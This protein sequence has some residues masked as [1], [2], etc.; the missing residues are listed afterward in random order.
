VDIWQAVLKRFPL[1]E[2]RQRRNA[3]AE[4][5]VVIR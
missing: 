3:L 5:R 4:R 1:I 2:G